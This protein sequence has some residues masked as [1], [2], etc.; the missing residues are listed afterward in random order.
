MN[1]GNF[2]KKDS[3][4]S[5]VDNGK[6]I[7]L[8]KLVKEYGKTLK[9]ASTILGINY[10]TAKTIL[11]VYRLERR[12]LKKSTNPSFK[13]KAYPIP[14]HHRPPSTQISFLQESYCLK[15]IE[16]L[17]RMT[18]KC[19]EQAANNQLILDR[20]ILLINFISSSSNKTGTT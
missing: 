18:Q 20:I 15:E 11:R 5:K 16:E 12:I 10:S 3:I 7:Q 19:L 8:L 14:S 1:S 4:Y 6:R 2:T 13:L 17:S 9:E